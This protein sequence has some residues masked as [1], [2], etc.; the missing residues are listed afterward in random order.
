MRRCGPKRTPLKCSEAIIQK[1][2]ALFLPGKREGA[3]PPPRARA[4]TCGPRQGF[5]LPPVLIKATTINMRADVFGLASKR[6]ASP[7][8]NNSDSNDKKYSLDMKY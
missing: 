2:R 8:D 3:D 1:S 4:R 7:A 5:E 6:W